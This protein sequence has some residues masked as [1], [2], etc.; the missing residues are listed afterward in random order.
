MCVDGVC[1]DAVCSGQ[2][3]SCSE[4]GNKGRCIAVSGAPRGTRRSPCAGT[5]DA[6]RGTCNGTS[7]TQCTYPGSNVTC[8]PASCS[9][10]NLTQPSVCNS[11]GDCTTPPPATPCRSGQC[12][13][14]AGQCLT[15]TAG[16][17]CGGGLVCDTNGG[18]CCPAGQGACGGVT[19]VDVASTPQHCGTSC[20]VCGGATP[21]CA[22]GNCVQ[23]VTD[24]DCGGSTPSCNPAIHAC[25]CRRPSPGNLFQNPGFEASLGLGEWDPGKLV[26]DNVPATWSSED[27]DGCSGSGSAHAVNTGLTGGPNQCVQVA[28]ETRYFFGARFKGTDFSFCQA[29]YHGDTS[30]GT[31]GGELSDFIGSTGSSTWSSSSNSLTTPAGVKSL[32]FYCFLINTSVDQLYLNSTSNS[33]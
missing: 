6:C 5:R 3:E 24:Q 18:V 31:F 27:S 17:A 10:G 19:C 32:L 30:C 4:T 33:Y 12:T 23:C 20:I 29:Q 13:T 11:L 8:V 26:A 22:S 16:L 14:T 2:C 25:T 21:R 1:C 28:A 15:C 7:R 9:A